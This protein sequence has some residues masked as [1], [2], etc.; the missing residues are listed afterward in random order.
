MST[1]DE[2]GRLEALFDRAADL[3]EVERSAF[4]EREC[5]A[6]VALGDE[7]RRLL[8]GLAGDDVLEQLQDEAPSRAGTT[9]GPYRLL[10]R[11]GLGGMGEVYAA[12]QTLPVVRRVALKLIRPGMGSAEIVARFQAERQALARMNHPHVAQVL[13]AG[14]ADDGRPYFVMEF[15]AGQPITEHADLRTLSTS[16]RLELFLAVCDGVQHAHQKGVIHRDLKP[17]NLLVTDENGSAIPKV[18]DFGVARATTGKL[19]GHTMHTL[20]GQVVG[21]LDYMSPEQADP[22]GVDVDTRS[23]VYSLGVLLYQ[24]LSGF[25]PFDHSTDISRPLAD[26]QRTIREE[27]PPK[28][29]TRLASQTDTA[30]KVARLHAS[31][32]RALTKQLTGDLDWICLRALEKDP[33]RRYQSVSELADDVRRHLADEPVLAAK[34]SAVYR[35][36]KFVRRHRV[37]VGA[38]TAV[39]IALIVGLLGTIL[40]RIEADRERA[41]VER[42]SAFQELDDLRSEADVLWPP[43]PDLR[44][45]YVD[46]LRRA[47]AVVAGLDP[48]ADGSSPGHRQ[49]LERLRQR[50]LPSSEEQDEAERLAYSATTEHASLDAKLK[51][52]RAAQAVRSG[53]AT[54]AT[55]ELPASVSDR[56]P[57]DISGWAWFL[58]GPD[59]TLF[60]REAEGLAMARFGL[61][62]HEGGLGG[63]KRD[64]LAWALFANGLDAEA[65]EIGETAAGLVGDERSR[66][67]LKASFDRLRAEV[68]AAANPSWTVEAET[69]L[70][71]LDAEIADHGRYAFASSDDTWWHQ[72]FEQLAG[73]IE[74]LADPQSGL[75]SGISTEHGWGITRRL[76][77]A[78]TVAE[79]TVTGTDASERWEQA[80][81]S[82]ADSP[83]YGGLEISPQLGLL[84]IGRDQESRLWEFWHVQSGDE[85]IRAEDGS[86]ELTPGSGLVLVLIPSGTF[87]MGAVKGEPGPYSHPSAILREW[88]VHEESLPAF[89]IS[90][91]EMTR[92][93]WERA[94]GSTPPVDPGTPTEYPLHPVARMSWWDAD[95]VTRWLGLGLPEEAQWEYAARAG[96]DTIWWTGN[97]E[98]LLRYAEN[99]AGRASWLEGST[100]PDSAPPDSGTIDEYDRLAPVG[101]FMANAFG[102]HDVHGNVSE[103]CVEPIWMYDFEYIGNPLSRVYR[104][105]NYR[106]SADD[107]RSSA[108]P[109]TG[110]EDTDEGIGLRP[111][112]S[113][114]R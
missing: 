79:L 102:L 71:A 47:E 94:T 53:A 56:D 72:R 81:A 91:F 25:L 60:G 73:E 93:Q 55:V 112:R 36:R 85:P 109:D 63:W 82:I 45:A 49:Q 40:A 19:A 69:A 27:E 24:L 111:V 33:Q 51:W 28:P 107:G 35:A 106:R 26:I 39:A 46:W 78:D 99:L 14:T 59:R 20:V 54:P 103:W 58:V 62:M 77:F 31:D 18:I 75:I 22:G 21:T 52:M 17:S 12:E 100:I 7:L 90:K 30:A 15:V 76:E 86:I 2:R 114:E 32:E 57:I 87:M 68:D 1:P 23:D 34:P 44:P 67:T 10:E 104:G 11:V 6:N 83:E 95:R 5:G 98:Y 16:E 80:L 74:D 50:A 3:P 29:S 92:S 105:G 37:G 48:S 70:A 13:D 97:D 61:E 38:G 64:T 108:R 66:D 8:A 88:P 65:L 84:P 4:V 42:L 41:N 101:T 96:T 110:P 9:I 113:I 89:F 43:T